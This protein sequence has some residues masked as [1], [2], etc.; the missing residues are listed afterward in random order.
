MTGES[1]SRRQWIHQALERYERPLVQYAYRFTGEIESA[2]DVVQDTFLRLCK[3]DR[4]LVDGHLAQWL[5]TVCRNRA[6]DVRKKEGRMHPDT[7]LRFDPRSNG[8]LTPRDRAERNE[9]RERLVA[10]VKT[11]PEAQQEVFFL[12]FQDDLSYRQIA[13]VT[14]K[15][16][17][18]VSN[19]V[20]AALK[21]VHQKLEPNLDSAQ[22]G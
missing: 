8:A 4:A 10:A 9:T 18:T 22:E 14:G 16:L 7:E 12:K 13:E 19:L 21:A 15:S 17:G 1:A 11:L 2:R 3:A 20:T 6:L 5:Y